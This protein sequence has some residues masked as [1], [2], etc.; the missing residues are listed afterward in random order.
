MNASSNFARTDTFLSNTFG[1][2]TTQLAENLVLDCNEIDKDDNEAVSVAIKDAEAMLDRHV[3]NGMSPVYK[4][5]AMC[6]IRARL[7]LGSRATTLGG[8]E[9]A[10]KERPNAPTPPTHT[11]AE[12]L[13][14]SMA[15]LIKTAKEA[16]MTPE[17]IRTVINAE[18][19]KAA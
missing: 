6:L 17:D 2:F 12:K 9:K 10:W 19:T 11:P 1:S 3:A 4:Y 7:K 8:G 16:G 18:I 5:R 15:K 13:A 14:K